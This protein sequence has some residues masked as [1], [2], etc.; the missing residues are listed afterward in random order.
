VEPRSEPL[1]FY[2]QAGDHELLTWGWAQERLEAAPTYWVV[3]PSVSHPHPRPVWGVWFD[4]AVHVSLGAPALRRACVPGAPVT[5]HLDD[6]LEVLIVEGVVRG[7]T[8]DTSVVAAYDAK[9]S[10]GYDLEQYG[11]LT[12]VDPARILAWRTA[13]EQGRD[14]FVQATRFRFDA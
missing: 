5:V 8:A 13:G 7:W 2:G 10:Y 1:S 6:G 12:T 14:G 9:Y 11:P 3:A 4:G